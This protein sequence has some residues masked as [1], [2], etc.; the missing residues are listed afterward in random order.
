MLEINKKKPSSR[1]WIKNGS[2]RIMAVVCLCI[3][4]VVSG[5]SSSKRDETASQDNLKVAISEEAPQA[6]SVAK[7]ANYTLSDTA[8]EN[9]T[10]GIAAA[11]E[12]KVGFTA[13]A[14]TDSWDRKVIYKGNLTMEVPDYAVAQTEINNLVTLTGGYILQFSENQSTAE[15][16]GN[17]VIK[18]PA[19]GFSSFIRDLEKIKTVSDIR[20]N[21]QGQDVSEEYVDLSSRL[22]AKQVVEA[23]LLAFME[24]AEKTAELLSFSNELGNV[25]EAIE[26][27]KGRMRFLDQNVSMSTVEIRLYQ[28]GAAKIDAGGD[29]T[30]TQIEDALKASVHALKVIAQGLIIFVAAVLPVLIVL[31]IIG[32][33][34]IIVIRKR[35]RKAA[36]NPSPPASYIQKVDSMEEPPKDLP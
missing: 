5:C 4:L 35:A 29:S 20:H 17:Y 10:I 7:D 3:W 23:R 18:V 6:A 21:I 22:K 33:P 36:L 30:L 2:G 11:A 32:I 1:M 13:A 8:T 25:Q 14:S 9:Q 31:A 16:S 34:L 24:K 19:N 26:Q 15:K 28:Q 12:S 27:I